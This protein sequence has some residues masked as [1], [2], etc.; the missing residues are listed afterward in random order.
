MAIAVEQA[1]EGVRTGNGDS[2][3][4]ILRH[5]RVHVEIT[6]GVLRERCLALY[7]R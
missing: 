2:C 3:E 5:A 4:Q 7:R 1:W 6:A